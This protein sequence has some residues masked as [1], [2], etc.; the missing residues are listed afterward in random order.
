[1]NST[2]HCDLYCM[3][4]Q[5]HIFY[6]GIYTM[7]STVCYANKWTIQNFL[8]TGPVNATFEISVNDLNLVSQSLIINE[9]SNSYDII[10]NPLF[11]SLEIG[12]TYYIGLI[13]TAPSIG[14]I[15]FNSTTKDPVLGPSLVTN[16]TLD[17]FIDFTMSLLN[18][19][20]MYVQLSVNSISCM[21]KTVLLGHNY[22]SSDLNSYCVDTLTFRNYYS[23]NP[24]ASFNATAYI[25]DPV[26]NSTTLS[27]PSLF[28]SQQSVS[29]TFTV[30]PT[31]IKP[32]Q[33][34]Y[35]GVVISYASGLIQFTVDGSEVPYSSY[36]ID[37]F[38]NFT[39]IDF[40]N[41]SATNLYVDMTFSG[42]TGCATNSSVAYSNSTNSSVA[43]SNSSKKIIFTSSLIGTPDRELSK[44][45]VAGIVI[46]S[47]AATGAAVGG[48]SYLSSKA[49]YGGCF[50]FTRVIKLCKRC[51][52]GDGDS[53][54]KKTE[55][56][57]KKKLEKELDN[58]P[59]DT[60]I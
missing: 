48:A 3:P 39:T 46:G 38:V 11:N 56:K 44:G 28:I 13:I 2:V 52:C 6:G 32:N 22:T 26:N 58:F 60:A 40:N 54:K 47:I 35:I 57:K 42:P 43:Y 29:F 24:E 53:L 14:Y 19:S 17:N 16:L 45:A 5:D 34:Y 36:R 49:G 51:I 55:E 23:D 7:Q 18:D 12:T 21:P 8:T 1:M 50:G 31:I 20:E 33:I 25:I 41:A 59:V 4:L 27:N 9:N 15:T 10:L 30:S 37:D